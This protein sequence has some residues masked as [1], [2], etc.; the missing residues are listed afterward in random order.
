MTAKSS[1]KVKICKSNSFLRGQYF[2]EKTS[3]IFQKMQHKKLNRT[4]P[5]GIDM[6][7]H[8]KNLLHLNRIIFHCSSSN[9]NEV[10]NIGLNYKNLWNCPS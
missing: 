10:V 7:E 5:S 1:A 6:I 4:L 8:Y 9:D 3:V 2:R